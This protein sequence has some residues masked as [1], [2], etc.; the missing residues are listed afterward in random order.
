MK[1]RPPLFQRRWVRTYWVGFGVSAWL[2]LFALINAATREVPL[3]GIVA[4]T[5]GSSALLVGALTAT[6]LARAGVVDMWFV[7][8]TTTTRTVSVGWIALAVSGV[9][10]SVVSVL[11][12]AEFEIVDSTSG[13]LGTIGAV[14][15]LA[16]VGP[17]YSEYREALSS[18]ESANEVVT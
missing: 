13:I 6:R 5:L 8:G 18:V 7:K 10:G 3:S 14:A 9:V 17:G 11:L 12:D 4:T 15:L 2:L 16:Q 1:T